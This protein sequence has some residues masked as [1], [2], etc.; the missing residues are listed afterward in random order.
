MVTQFS[1]ISSNDYFFLDSASQ[2]QYARPWSLVK[3]LFAPFYSPYVN[4]YA[5]Y[6]NFFAVKIF[7]RPFAAYD[8]DITSEYPATLVH[9]TYM[10][11]E[12][13]KIEA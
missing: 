5:I 4:I 2:R 6:F 3:D 13:L 12:A 10:C 8:N 1:T 9:L 11:R 7:T